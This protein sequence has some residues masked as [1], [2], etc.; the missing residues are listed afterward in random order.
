MYR[1]ASDLLTYAG[2]LAILTYNGKRPDNFGRNIPRLANTRLRRDGDN[3][4]VLFHHT[5]ILVVEPDGD[6]T[7]YAGRY[8]TFTT[9][10][11]IK[12]FTN[13]QLY[14]KAHV[15]YI[16]EGALPGSC[17]HHKFYDGIT[18]YADGTVL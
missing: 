7:L 3:I 10:E 13:A 16:Q 1:P 18:V 8:R 2:L 5:R 9:K 4:E 6:K 14:Q 12:L 17:R 11:R 15:W